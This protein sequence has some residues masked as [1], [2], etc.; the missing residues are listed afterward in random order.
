MYKYLFV[1]IFILFIA[2][3]SIWAQKQIKTIKQTEYE[4]VIVDNIP[5][6]G[7]VICCN[8][9]YQSF[10]K[11]GNLLEE[12]KYDV[13]GLIDEREIFR[14]DENG[15]EI[16]NILYIKDNY[17]E[18]KYISKYDKRSN[19]LE[20]QMFNDENVLISCEKM[21]YDL[22]GMLIKL[23]ETNEKGKVVRKENKRYNER[24]D[25]VFDN[26]QYVGKNG[27]GWQEVFLYNERGKLMRFIGYS[28]CIF[29]PDGSFVER[30]LA[31]DNE[32]KKYELIYN[33]QFLLSQVRLYN[34]KSLLKKQWTYNYEDNR[35]SAKSLFDGEGKLLQQSLYSQTSQGKKIIILDDKKQIISQYEYDKY[36]NLIEIYENKNGVL[37]SIKY[38]Y[39][40]NGNDWITMLTFD[41]IKQKYISYTEREIVYY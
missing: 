7:K 2:N 31:E 26:C 17:I 39:H 12:I 23:I 6:K 11:Q 4:C 41:K 30:E 10:D 37:T 20:K 5:Q 40:Y 34:E 27:F 38:D 15:N 24:G 8:N 32:L 29:A 35:C 36:N 1:L 14:F 22:N 19:L 33:E 13:D 16:E 3:N 18:Y 21:T 9:F 25:I 28:D